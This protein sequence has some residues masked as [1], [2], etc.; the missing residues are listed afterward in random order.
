MGWGCLL[1]DGKVYYGIW[2]LKTPI[3]DS[4]LSETHAHLQISYFGYVS[5]NDLQQWR[6]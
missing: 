3:P 4:Y 2:I 1:W 5:F 6:K